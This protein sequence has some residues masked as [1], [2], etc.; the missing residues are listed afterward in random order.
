[1]VIE[2]RQHARGIRADGILHPGVEAIVDMREDDVEIGSELTKRFHCPQPVFLHP[3]RHARAKIQKL[4][5]RRRVVLCD[6]PYFDRVPACLSAE[7]PRVHRR[8]SA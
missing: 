2:Q 6:P 7:L 4:P 1:M 8:S 3:V 5:Q